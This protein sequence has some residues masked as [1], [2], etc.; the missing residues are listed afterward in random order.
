MAACLSLFSFT[1]CQQSQN[2]QSA[3]ND[4]TQQAQ[5]TT[6]A[7]TET[8]AADTSSAAALTTVMSVSEKVKAGAPVLVKFTVTNSSDK[9]VEFC[10]WH[11]P[12]EEKFLNSFFEIQDSKGEPAQ[13]TGVMAKR[14]M[15]PPADAFIKVPAKGTVS[16]EIDLL[17]GYK[18]SAPGTYKVI[19]QGDGIS[20][21]T[22]VNE[23]TFTIE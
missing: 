5:D 19:Y 11:T 22:K 2:A 12:F 4:T 13:Y 10:K 7:L 1:A 20:G 17:K 8:P 6:A 16:A 3:Q 14:I 9:E 15:P 18:V 21:L 23:V